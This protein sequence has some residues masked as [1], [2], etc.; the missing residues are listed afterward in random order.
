ML[1]AVLRTPYSAE[2]S[3]ILPAF[4][5]YVLSSA[6]FQAIILDAS[7]GTTNQQELSLAKVK[8][9]F[10][11]LP[12]FAEQRRIVVKLDEILAEVGK[13]EQPMSSLHK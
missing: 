9:L 11:P 2:Q 13:Q 5:K 6:T 12:P 7:L 10:I 4:I 3:L 1:S 8:Q